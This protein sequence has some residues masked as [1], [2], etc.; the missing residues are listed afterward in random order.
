MKNTLCSSALSGHMNCWICLSRYDVSETRFV[1]TKYLAKP[2]RATTGT[3][4]TPSVILES[5]PI[6]PHFTHVLYSHSH[7]TC[8]ATTHKGVDI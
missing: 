8:I 6:V 7:W 4:D 2:L 5:S 3:K 1:T